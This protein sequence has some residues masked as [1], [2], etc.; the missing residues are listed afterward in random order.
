[1]SQGVICT[2]NLPSSIFMSNIISLV[3]IF[4]KKTKIKMFYLHRSDK[5]QKYTQN[6]ECE[7]IFKVNVIECTIPLRE[8]CPVKKIGNKMFH[9]CRGY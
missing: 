7:G 1:M 9:A 2:K 3:V 5:K 8:I 6:Y 4:A